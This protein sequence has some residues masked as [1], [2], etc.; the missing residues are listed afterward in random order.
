ML[1]SPTDIWSNSNAAM[2]RSSVTYGAYCYLQSSQP[3]RCAEFLL[4]FPLGLIFDI[5]HVRRLG[6]KV[7]R[8][9]GFGLGHSGTKDPITRQSCISH[10][11][12]T[13]NCASASQE[14]RQPH[15]LAP[16][17]EADLPRLPD[18]AG[19]SDRGDSAAVALPNSLSYSVRAWSAGSLSRCHLVIDVRT[20]AWWQAE[21]LV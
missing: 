12:L 18:T 3:Q 21:T 4:T 1:V 17:P 9:V 16:T 10:T 5:D 11:R 19:R 8:S 2:R 7:R 6:T 20:P 14:V 13:F 15:R